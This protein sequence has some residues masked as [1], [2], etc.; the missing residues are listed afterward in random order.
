MTMLLRIGQRVQSLSHSFMRTAFNSSLA[1]TELSAPSQDQLQQADAAADSAAGYAVQPVAAN[2]PQ[3]HGVFTAITPLNN[4]L[5][6]FEGGYQPG[7]FHDDTRYL[8]Q[9]SARVALQMSLNNATVEL[10]QN[11]RL[12]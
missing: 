9:V 1:S 10:G 7:N 5:Q 11:G 3:W 4:D 6:T 2:A 8:G 12:Q